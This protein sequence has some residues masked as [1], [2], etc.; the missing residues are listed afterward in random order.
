MQKSHEICREHLKNAEKRNTDLYDAKNSFH[1]YKTGDVVW[2]QHKTRKE[3]L[4]PKLQMPYSGPF[5]IQKKISNQNYIIQ[6]S[7]SVSDIKVIHYDKLKPY[8]GSC[9]TKWISC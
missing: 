3:S 9:P 4:C 2:Y 7:E 6:F 1:N 8:Q 5:L